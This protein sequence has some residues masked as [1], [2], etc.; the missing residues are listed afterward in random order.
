MGDQTDTGVPGY[1]VGK[2]ANYA[3]QQPKAAAEE[4][5]PA[6]TQIPGGT[7]LRRRPEEPSAAAAAAEAANANDTN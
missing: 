6:N 5:K 2:P 4:P 3:D 1:F 7:L